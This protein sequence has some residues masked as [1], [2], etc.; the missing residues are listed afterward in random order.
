[1]MELE[2]VLDDSILVQRNWYVGRCRD[3]MLCGN[4]VIIE[5]GNMA[6]I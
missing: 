5:S 6:H 4:I 2:K 3:K 1:M